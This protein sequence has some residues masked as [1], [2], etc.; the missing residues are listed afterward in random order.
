MIESTYSFSKLISE[1]PKQ[2]LSIEGRQNFLNNG[3]MNMKWLKHE[4]FEL[5]LAY[6]SRKHP[7]LGGMRFMLHFP[8]LL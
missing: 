3:R 1:S 7:T 8:S 2:L 4:C 5:N 6:N